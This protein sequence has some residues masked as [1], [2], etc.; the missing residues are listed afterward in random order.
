MCGVQAE[1]EAPIVPAGR[2]QRGELGISFNSMTAS[3]EDL[4]RE[5]AEKKRLEEELRLLLLPRDPNEGRNVIVEVRGAEGGEEA[6][7]FARDL[8]E[9]GKGA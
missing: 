2:D 3:I 7:L 1:A 4:L 5:Q 9:I 8:F 6:N